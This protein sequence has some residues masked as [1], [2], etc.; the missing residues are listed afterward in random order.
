MPNNE[1]LPLLK[2]QHLQQQ[3]LILTKTELDTNVNIQQ[4]KKIEPAQEFKVVDK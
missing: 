3:S 2:F 4:L 1:Q